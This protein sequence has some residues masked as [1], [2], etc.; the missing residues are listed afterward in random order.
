MI[1]S[2]ILLTFDLM[3]S[4]ILR[5]CLTPVTYPWNLRRGFK[6]W[7]VFAN[8]WSTHIR[9][10]V[11]M[12][13]HTSSYKLIVGCCRLLLVS[14]PSLKSRAKCRHH[15]PPRSKILKWFSGRANLLPPSEG[16]VITAAAHR[17]RPS[18]YMIVR[19]SL[20]APPTLVDLLQ[21]AITN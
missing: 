8:S 12:Y 1:P 14:S 16:V 4:E 6:N 2:K 13:I 3:I 10:L 15:S 18:L 9:I 5:K 19:H 11:P 7:K 17:L 21:L 20:L